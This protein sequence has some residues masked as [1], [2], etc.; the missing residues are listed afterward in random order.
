MACVV[1]D[2]CLPVDRLQ[3]LYRGHVN[4]VE[5][6]SRDGRRINLPAYHLRPFVTHSGVHGSFELE[7]DDSGRLLALRR[8]A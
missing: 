7:F 1:L 8:L 6:V 3:A 2:I 4:R 5:V